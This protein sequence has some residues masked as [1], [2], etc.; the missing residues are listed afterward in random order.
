MTYY[1]SLGFSSSEIAGAVAEAAIHDLRVNLFSFNGFPQIL[2]SPKG[3][4]SFNVTLSWSDPTNSFVE[5]D[6]SVAEARAAVE[7][8]RAGSGYDSAIFDR[9]QISLASLEGKAGEAF[10]QS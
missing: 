10:R 8:F 4:D 9:V 3:N 2:I 1:A 6:L 5:F 7:K